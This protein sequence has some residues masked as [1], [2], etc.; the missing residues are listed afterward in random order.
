MQESTA[1]CAQRWC[2]CI[3]ACFIRRLVTGWCLTQVSFTA[4][5]AACASRE[6]ER[7]PG[8]QVAQLCITVRSVT[9]SL[10]KCYLLI[11][12][13]ALFRD[14]FC[15]RICSRWACCLH[16]STIMF[17][18]YF[19]GDFSAETRNIGWVQQITRG[20]RKR[21]AVVPSSSSCI[22]DGRRAMKE[23]NMTVLTP[24]LFIPRGT[25]SY[26][27]GQQS[28]GPE[29]LITCHICWKTLQLS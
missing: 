15:L 17:S 22:T 11:Q 3:I 9:V 12:L 14:C 24:G 23:F 19:K 5:S 25:F 28:K 4:H 16:S 27:W 29:G 13:M 6:H 18:G 7:Q 8:S 2:F 20:Y 1:V 26:H 21:I 10:L